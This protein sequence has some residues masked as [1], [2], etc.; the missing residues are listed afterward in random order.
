[1][2]KKTE[3][4]LEKLIEMQSKPD[5]VPVQ[6]PVQM[7][8]DTIDVITK[9]GTAVC[10]AVIIG[11]AVQLMNMSTDLTVMKSQMARFETFSQEERFTAKDNIAAD[12]ELLKEITKV[13]EDL[14]DDIATN[15]NEI[16]MIKSELGRRTTFM[17]ETEETVDGVKK[18]LRS[19]KNYR[20]F[21]ERKVGEGDN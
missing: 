16:K 15:A 12:A 13:V 20:T 2:T 9:I 17:D 1:M 5:P 7:K 19:L 3:E 14:G 8:H 11:V 21:L 10:T 18:R 6:E 4:L